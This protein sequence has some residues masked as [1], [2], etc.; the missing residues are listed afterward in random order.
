MIYPLSA[1]TNV[2]AKDILGLGKQAIDWSANPSSATVDFER[3]HPLFEHVR[4]TVVEE[5]AGKL[6][7]T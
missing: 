4:K 7:S 1:K 3:F 2:S 6:D 5:G